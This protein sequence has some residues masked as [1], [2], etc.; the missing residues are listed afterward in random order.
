[1]SPPAIASANARTARSCS[2]RDAAKRGLS[3]VTWRRAREASCRTASGVRPTTSATSPNGTSKTS[4]NTNAVRSA[5]E[6]CSS[7]VSSA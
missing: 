3:C 4:C 2:S 1:M 5:G 7:T 6:S